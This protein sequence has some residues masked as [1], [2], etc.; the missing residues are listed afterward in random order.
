MKK[1]LLVILLLTVLAT[2]L[3][4]YSKGNTSTTNQQTTSTEKKPLYWVDTME[5]DVHYSAPGKS[6][7][8]MDLVPVYSE[9]QKK[10][11]NKDGKVPPAKE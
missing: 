11:D 7:M 4:G 8:G 6:R 1:K 2:P 5:P 9:P 3:I 10:T